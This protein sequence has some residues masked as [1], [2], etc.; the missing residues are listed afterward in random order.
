MNFNPFLRNLLFLALFVTVKCSFAQV[1]LNVRDFGAKGDGVHD[2]STSIHSAIQA[3]SKKG[4]GTT[5]FFPKGKYVLTRQLGV[6]HS[7]YPA[8]ALG[9]GVAPED[10]DSKMNANLIL[11]NLSD[12]TLEGEEGTLLAFHSTEEDGVVMD[13]CRNVVIKNIGV[14]YDPLPFTQGVIE[15]VNE[16]TIRFTLEDGYPNPTQGYLAD[17]KGKKLLLFFN[18]KGEYNREAGDK[19]A[20][21]VKSLG[22]NSFELDLFGHDTTEGL[23]KGDRLAY[24][25]RAGSFAVLLWNCEKCLFDHFQ[26]YSSP[27]KAIKE[28][29]SADITYRNCFIGRMPGTNRLAVTSADGISSTCDRKGPTVEGCTVQYTSD[30]CISYNNNQQLVL[31]SKDPSHFN[32][33]M[34]KADYRIGDRVSVWDFQTGKVRGEAIVKSLRISKQ[35]KKNLILEVTTDKPIPGVVPFGSP[36]AQP[37]VSHKKGSTEPD[38]GNSNQPGDVMNNLNSIGADFVFRNNTLGPNRARGILIETQKGIIEGNHLTDI[39]HMAI[40]IGIDP[41]GHETVPCEDILIQGNTFEHLRCGPAIG[42]CDWGEEVSEVINHRSITV[43]NNQFNDCLTAVPLIA[44]S[45][46]GSFK[47]LG[48]TILNP[49]S[50]HKKSYTLDK[51][52]KN[53]TK[54]FEVNSL[55]E[56][57]FVFLNVCESVEV[58]NNIFQSNG[59]IMDWVGFGPKA[60][61]KQIVSDANSG[62]QK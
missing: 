20:E 14:D 35:Q 43:Q 51:V 41:N 19:F 23:A 33:D 21:N 49:A 13:R 57:T 62:E 26:V 38:K 61:R 32:I 27:M 59:H 7:N 1:Q 58:K 12:I 2:D 3:A 9:E 24:L 30:D 46:L 11:Q 39:G 55:P 45:N 22:N 40:K 37:K 50:N 44:G 42:I 53:F 29:Q 56:N 4:P 18:S 6:R 28:N 16:K 52:I 5:L 34:K 36:E 48:N 10:L 54:P 60:N 47:V 31:G 15:S 25:P 8:S 17:A